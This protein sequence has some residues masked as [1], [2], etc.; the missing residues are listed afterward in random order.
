MSLPPSQLNERNVQSLAL[1][2]AGTEEFDAEYTL[3][4]S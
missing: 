4:L 1:D 3:R 2:F